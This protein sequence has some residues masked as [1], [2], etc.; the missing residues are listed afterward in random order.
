[1]TDTGIIAWG[2]DKNAAHWRAHLLSDRLSGCFP[3]GLSH[4]PTLA[5][6]RLMTGEETAKLCAAYADD[7]K[8]EKIVIMDV[9]GISPIADYFVICTASSAPHLRAVQNEIDERM[10]DEHDQNPRWRDDNYE[11]QWLILDYSDVMVHIFHEEKRD[12]YRLEEL[13]GDAKM[14]PWTPAP[15]PVRAA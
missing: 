10:H 3:C 14:V 5:P 4:D 13:W 9:R 11:S 8:A 6:I 2:L 1:M 7:K 15:P 12:F